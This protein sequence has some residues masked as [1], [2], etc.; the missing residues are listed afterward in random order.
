MTVAL[1]TGASGG[2]GGA[3]ADR[4]ARRGHDFI[5]VGR[6]QARLAPRAEACRA[7][8]A[9]V[10][11]MV[12]DLTAPDDL[13]RVEQRL[14]DDPAIGMLVNAAGI[15]TLDKLAGGDAEVI[16]AMIQTNVLA[17]ARLAATAA[18]AFA[19]RGGG[20]II[21]LSAVLAL[22]PEIGN[23]AYAGSKAFVGPAGV[24]V[25]AV[26][27]GMTRTGIWRQ[28]GRDPATLPASKTMEPGDLV[29]AALAGLD[30]GETVTIPTL[31]DPA[32]WQALEAARHRLRPHLSNREA[33]PRYRT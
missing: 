15:A 18:A 11:V 16:A 2:I 22:A 4:L 17:L 1:I 23:G 19:G 27:P 8:G 24:R 7:A 21:N 13:G 26:L 31:P 25:Q 6:N 20:T 5:L 33:A 28:S 12:A 3:Y 30:A 9:A 10:D 29:D 14:R 32:D